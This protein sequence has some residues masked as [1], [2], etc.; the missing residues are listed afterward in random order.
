MQAARD[1]IALGPD[2]KQTLADVASLANVSAP[3]QAE[4]LWQEYCRHDALA[5][6]ISGGDTDNHERGSG[7]T[8]LPV[9]QVTEC[10]ADRS[11]SQVEDN[12]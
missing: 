7:R 6:S 2:A 10:Q 11:Y 8:N 1:E 5:A 3:R 12:R 9:T 4:P